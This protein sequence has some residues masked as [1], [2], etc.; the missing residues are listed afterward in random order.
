[1]GSQACLQI[2][3]VGGNRYVARMLIDLSD[4]LKEKEHCVS[5]ILN[6][7]IGPDYYT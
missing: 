5:S 3:Y 4:V 7:D 2:E 1:M 6:S